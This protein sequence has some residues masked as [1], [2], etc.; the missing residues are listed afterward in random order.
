MTYTGK[1]FSDARYTLW[2][3]RSMNHN[4]PLIGGFEQA[5]GWTRGARDV[6]KLPDGLRLDMAPAYPGEAGVLACRRTAT[7]SEAGCRVEDEIRLEKPNRVTEVFLLRNRPVIEGG[8]VCAGRIR[9]APDRPM[10]VGI[11]EIHV[12]DTRMARSYPGSLWRVC[13]TTRESCDIRLR[14]EISER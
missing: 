4:L 11:E 1:T 8:D 9:I 13:F 10:D 6:E 3:T 7:C 14:F 12:T 5:D 2:N